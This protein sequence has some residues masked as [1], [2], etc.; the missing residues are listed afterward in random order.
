MKQ[1]PIYLVSLTTRI[2]PTLRAD[3]RA[4]AKQDRLT[5]SAWVAGVLG[6]TIAARKKQPPTAK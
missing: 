2:L 1:K 5:P 6:R 3:V 4:A